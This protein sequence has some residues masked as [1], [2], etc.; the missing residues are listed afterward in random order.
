L[1][2]DDSK[3]KQEQVK[4]PPGIPVSYKQHERVDVIIVPVTGIDRLEKIPVELK[5]TIHLWQCT[6]LLTFIHNPAKII[7]LILRHIKI[8]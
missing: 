5:Q 4:W 1:Q 7:H 6:I 3:Y 2:V 8:D